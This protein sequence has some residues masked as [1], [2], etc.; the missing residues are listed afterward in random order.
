MSENLLDQQI[1][2]WIYLMFDILYLKSTDANHL[3]YC[4]VGAALKGNV[5]IEPVYKIL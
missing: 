3:E 2:A 4:A 5:V 1:R